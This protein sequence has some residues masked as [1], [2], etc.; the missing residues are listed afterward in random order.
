MVIL[1]TVTPVSFRTGSRSE[2]NPTRRPPSRTWL[3][4]VSAEPLGLSKISC[5]VGTNGSPLLALYD[6]NT[7]TTATSKVT[8]PTSTGLSESECIWRRRVT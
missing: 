5:L 3:P 4:A 8:A 6:R 2:T 1:A 7:A